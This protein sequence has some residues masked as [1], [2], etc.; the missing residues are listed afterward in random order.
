MVHTHNGI[1]LTH[2]KACYTEWRKSE[3]E[4]QKLYINT[5]IWNLE[6]CYW[7]TYL[8]GRNRDTDI[9]NRLVGTVGEAEKGM[10]WERSTEIYITPRVTQ[11]AQPAALWWPRGVGWGGGRLGRERVYVY[12]WLVHCVV[13]QKSTQYSSN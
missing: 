9:E 3:R 11:A 4:K 7:W 8:W 1:L 13:Q 5:Y 2:K 12:L 10:N 6:K